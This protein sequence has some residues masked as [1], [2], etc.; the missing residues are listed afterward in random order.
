MLNVMDYL[1]YSFLFRER[2]L[3]QRNPDVLHSV[4]FRGAVFA[5]HSKFDRC[6]A[7]WLHALQLSQL[8]KISVTK[9]LLR[10]AQVSR[11]V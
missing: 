10:F 8:N 11:R 1:S 5:D 4:V 3:G 2:I 9:D 6:I 7:L